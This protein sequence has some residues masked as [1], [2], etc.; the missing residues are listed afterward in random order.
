MLAFYD[1]IRTLADIPGLHAG[2]TALIFGE[3]RVSYPDFAAEAGR[4]AATFTACGLVRGDRVAFLGTDSDRSLALLFGCALAG[5][6]FVPINWKLDEDDLAY[7]VADSGAKLLFLTATTAAAGAR[8][9]AACPDLK[10]VVAIDGDDDA[11]G[12]GAWL[13]QAGGPVP[14]GGGDPD[15]PVIQVYTSGTSGRPKGV[16]LGHRGFIDVVREIERAGDPFIDWRPGDVSLLALPSFHV[17]GLWWAIQGLINGAAN[18]VLPAFAPAAALAAIPRWKIT[19]LAFVPAMLRF[20]LS[21]P[22]AAETDTSSVGM[23][24][25]GGSP[26]PRPVLE[27]A[28]ALFRCPFA[29]N[30]GLSETSN[31]AI[32]LPADEHADL[33]ARNVP[34]AGR[35]LRGVDVRIIDADGRDLPAG[36]TGEILFRTPSRMLC[37]W[38]Q[39]EATARTLVDGWLYTGD[40]GHLDSE[41]YLHI[42]DR[43]KDLIISAGEN[44]Y[45]AE[46]ERALAAHPDISDVAVIGIPDKRWG[47]V[48]FAYVVPRAGSGLDRKT[49]MAYA[50]A[51]VAPFKMIRDVAFIDQLP[52]N[53]AGKILKRVLREP[54]WAGLER[55]VN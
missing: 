50:R 15:E 35:P 8:V 5:M 53:S 28:M 1:A 24:I 25:Y 46:I 49:V 14:A 41:G 3:R 22:A 55:R 44:I 19:K 54:H 6:V 51:V 18:V 10:Q 13:T 9:A 7:I 42:T 40:A 34:A 20:M 33:V 31:M 11:G 45:P 23:V 21:E 17:G 27:A 38:R 26:M 36:E 32:F 2:G 29:Q 52:R 12:Y 39:P 37:Y 16:V 47:E 30:Y 48:P 4:I 43:I